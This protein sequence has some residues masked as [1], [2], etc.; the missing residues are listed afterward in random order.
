M[1]YICIMR[2]TNRYIIIDDSFNVCD[3]EEIMSKVKGL[4]HKFTNKESKRF[5]SFYINAK[6]RGLDFNIT[7]NDYLDMLCN[8]CNYCGSNHGDSIDRIYSTKGYTKDNVQLVCSKCN[9]MKYT[10]TDDEFK[11]HIISIYN[12]ISAQ[13]FKS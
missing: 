4:R 9:M 10:F 12:N 3:Y 7:Y 8:N 5:L 11:K 13:R 2:Y 6:R 1:Y